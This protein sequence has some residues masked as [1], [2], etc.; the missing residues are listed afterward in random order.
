MSFL[1]PPFLHF[2]AHRSDWPN[3]ENPL[4]DTIDVMVE[5]TSYSNIFFP[6]VSPFDFS[7]CLSDVR[8][9]FLQRWADLG[10]FDAPAFPRLR[11]PVT[12]VLR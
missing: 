6:F 4:T 7:L 8:L 1:F 2:S 3:F 12:L 5:R 10:G 11:N 9:N